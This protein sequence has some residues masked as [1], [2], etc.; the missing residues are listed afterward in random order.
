MF[1]CACRS[2]RFY[3]LL[4]DGHRRASE[5]VD[6]YRYRPCCCP[7]RSHVY[8]AAMNGH[9]RG[10]W[11]FL[12]KIVTHRKNKCCCPHAC[13]VMCIVG[14]RLAEK[15]WKLHTNWTQASIILVTFRILQTFLRV[16]RKQDR[17]SRAVPEAHP[18]RQIN[19]ARS[20]SYNGFWWCPFLCWTGGRKS[21]SN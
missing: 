7:T 5:M 16:S 6:F 17:L 10:L 2:I 14:S 13:V 11:K 19:I 21:L 8:R 20:T 4:T 12:G 15:Y 3:A 9:G 18:K 1:A